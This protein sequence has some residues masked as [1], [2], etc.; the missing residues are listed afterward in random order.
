MQWW[1][2]TSS[3]DADALS[4][5]LGLTDRSNADS[6]IASVVI[7]GTN[8]IQ[9]MQPEC[10]WMHMYNMKAHASMTVLG[11]SQMLPRKKYFAH[12]LHYT[13]MSTS[14]TCMNM[15]ATLLA[16]NAPSEPIGQSTLAWWMPW[17]LLSMYSY[18]W[19]SMNEH[20]STCHNMIH[21]EIVLHM[22]MKASAGW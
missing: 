11:T 10:S 6:A 17:T 13:C 22:P 18:A 20:T 14:Y 12:G 7:R 19:I 1:P 21:H 15:I 8:R 4:S 16:K 3:S 9:K 2:Q 5:N